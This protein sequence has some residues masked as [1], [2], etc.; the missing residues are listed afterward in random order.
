MR[1]IRWLKSNRWLCSF[2]VVVV[3]KVAGDGRR[4][5][6]VPQSAARAM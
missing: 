1:S 2:Y 5:S 6:I 3:K 4:T